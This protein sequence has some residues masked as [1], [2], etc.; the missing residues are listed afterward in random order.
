MRIV[1]ALALFLLLSS[2]AYA[3]ETDYNL[4]VP[5]SEDFKAGYSTGIHSGARDVSG[6][7]DLDGDG[8]P[9]ILV[10]DYTGGG[11]VHMVEHV[12]GNDWELV[13]TTAWL[14]STSTTNNIRTI[15][16]GDL[17]GDGL[18]EVYFLG[19]RNYS[20][21]NP[22][23]AS[24]PPGLYG[25]EVTG[26]NTFSDLPTT[27]YEFDGDLPD[28]WRAERM[29]IK[30]VD[31]DGEEELMFGNNGSNNA[32]D[33]WYILSVNGDIGSGF[34][35]WVQEARL[36]SRGSEDF[37]PANRGGGSPYDILA[38][39]LDGDGQME[40]SLHSWNN[41]NLA[42]GKATGANAYEFPADTFHRAYDSDWVAFFGGT[43]V[44]INSD[45]DD[46]IFY[47]RLQGGGLTVINYE[48]GEDPLTIGPD[49]VASDIATPGA[50]LGITAG[51][52]DGD[53]N[54]E[55]ISGGTSLTPASLTQDLELVRI[56]EFTGG[57]GGDPE[58]P[59]NYEVTGVNVLQDFDRL[60]SNF[61]LIKRD[62]A[63]VM[64]EYFETPGSNRG[65]GIGGQGAVFV[66]KLAYL[67]DID[68]DGAN[69]LAVAMQ[70]VDDSTYV[71]QEVFNPADSTYTRTVESSQAN[72]NRV[73]MRIISG[74]GF[75]VNVED[76]RIV[77]P[78]DYTLHANYPNPFNP[79][80]SFAFTLPIQKA[81]SVKVY[82]VAGRL[83][84][85]LV[86]NQFYAQGTHE[87]S[88]DG[89]SD[90]GASVASGTYLYTLEYGNFRQSRTMVLLK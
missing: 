48:D 66:S 4:N 44:D 33:N 42:V 50:D 34:E 5:L 62:S 69:E 61:D 79:T 87:V 51:D 35:V 24:L 45:G 39:D 56:T 83:V 23:I 65:G 37:D 27:I 22:N 31:G 29:H 72:E 10:A 85:T 53:G 7:H 64:S 32:Y 13:A 43:V 84:K 71:I 11:R 19:G 36:S 58:D 52:L 88:W 14:D 81:I 68:G 41:F 76:A 8:K 77:M 90:A 9:E 89:T 40:I 54:M 74:D 67:G 6:P 49:N 82:D 25:F 16:A 60:E 78:D 73:F 75:S 18:G 15:A 38:G 80:T 63:G 57:E 12:S 70:G 1:T 28:R 20:A 2:S 30:D 86:N 55:L 17:D 3:Q 21:T 46:E 47:G 26:D 59:A